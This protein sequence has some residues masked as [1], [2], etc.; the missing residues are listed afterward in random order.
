MDAEGHRKKGIHEKR[1]KCIQRE[2][3]SWKETESSREGGYLLLEQHAAG[4]QTW[5]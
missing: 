4:R 2:L 1:S 3:G 5:I